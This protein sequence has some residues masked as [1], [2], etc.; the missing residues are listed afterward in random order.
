MLPLTSS[1]D[2]AR[3]ESISYNLYLQE[4]ELFGID[5]TPPDIKG[6]VKEK[7]NTA[8]ENTEKKIK[9]SAEKAVENSVKKATEKISEEKK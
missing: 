6:I 8:I 3:K 4:L 7:A 2:K 1:W 5:N 9:E